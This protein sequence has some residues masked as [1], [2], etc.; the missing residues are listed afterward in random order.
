MD[1][2]EAQARN[3]YVI[4][5]IPSPHDP[6]NMTPAVGRVRSQNF[7]TPE[8]NSIDSRDPHGYRKIVGVTEQTRVTVRHYMIIESLAGL[9]GERFFF[10]RLDTYRYILLNNDRK[11]QKLQGVQKKQ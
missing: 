11:V 7:Y 5:G 9:P 4:R 1:T 2:K 8:T 10:V 3:L 6:A